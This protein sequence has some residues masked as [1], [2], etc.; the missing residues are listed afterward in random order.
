[1]SIAKNGYLLDPKVIQKDILAYGPVQGS[2]YI[3]DDF[4]NYG[5]GNY[6]KKMN[7]YVFAY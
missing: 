4:M 6:M 1:M 5:S 3:Y 2:M 7:M